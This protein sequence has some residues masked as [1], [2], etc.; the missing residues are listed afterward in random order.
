[1]P[2]VNDNPIVGRPTETGTLI[3]GAAAAL[4]IWGFGIDNPNVAAPLTL[5]LGAIPVS[6][7]F[8]VDQI[9]RIKRA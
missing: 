8:I 3:A 7:T 9:I 1:M 6:I 4:I 5:V 2:R